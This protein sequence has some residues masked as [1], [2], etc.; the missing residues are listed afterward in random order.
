[1]H[2]PVLTVVG[3]IGRTPRQRVL[4]NGTIVADFRLASTPRR[5]DKATSSWNDGDTT[6]FGV[7]CWRALAEHCAQSLGKGD[8]VIVTGRLTT[9]TWVNDQGEERSSL[10]IDATA[11][12]F[13]LTRG[14]VTQT[15]VVRTG[16][17]E[18]V[19]GEA[20]EP[21]AD[22]AAEAAAA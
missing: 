18:P 15:R 5:F 3:N 22:P 10:E 19:A 17:S 1:M 11:V 16:P 2:E 21:A 12:G 6:W 7:T 20:V 13:D 8:R 9:R 4:A 14:P